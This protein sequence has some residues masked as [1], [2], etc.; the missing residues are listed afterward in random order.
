MDEGTFENISNA[1]T[2][3]EVWDI[4]QNTQK[5]IDKVRKVRLQTLEREFENLNM[6]ELES[7]FDYFSKV[8]TIMNLL[9]RNSE[10]LNDTCV[11]EKKYF[12]L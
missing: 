7:I 1:T 4:L 6:K 5:G 10:S 9:K 8:L 12:D 11:I 3:M 2:S